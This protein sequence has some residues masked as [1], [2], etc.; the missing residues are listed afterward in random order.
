MKTAI[1]VLAALAALGPVGCGD[2]DGSD[3]TGA[4]EED[5]RQVV[6]DAID[7][8]DRRDFEELCELSSSEINE[9]I[10]QATDQDDCPSGYEELFR[11][12]DELEGKGRPFDEFVET[13]TNTE[14]GDATLSEDG[15]TVALESPDGPATSYLLSEDGELKVQEL[16]LSDRNPAAQGTSQAVPIPE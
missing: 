8:Y 4:S 9:S 2:D 15:A 10:P 5:A 6:I 14:V 7:A 3:A 16:Y 1:A 13:L 11:R 12:Q